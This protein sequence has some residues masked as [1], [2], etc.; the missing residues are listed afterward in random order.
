MTK[1]PQPQLAGSQGFPAIITLKR[2]SIR[3]FPDHKVV[4]LYYSDKLK[5][6]FSIPNE[7][8]DIM[9]EDRKISKKGDDLKNKINM[10]N[11]IPSRLK[12]RDYKKTK[13]VILQL[14]DIVKNRQAKHVNFADGTNKTVDIFT[15]AALLKTHSR[16]GNDNNKIRH[17]IMLNR[18][19][20]TFGRALDFTKKYSE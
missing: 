3:Y 20:D 10:V 16:L 6:Y 1:K 5:R 12:I 4:A 14:K 8:S 11:P 7:S 15:A 2:I 17:A 19:K 9:S 18:N 13:G